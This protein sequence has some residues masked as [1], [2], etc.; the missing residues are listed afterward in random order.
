MCEP[1]ERKLGTQED[2]SARH[3]HET[4]TCVGVTTEDERNSGYNALI[5]ASLRLRAN[6]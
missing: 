1:V 5:S 4:P 3:T 6:P 2:M